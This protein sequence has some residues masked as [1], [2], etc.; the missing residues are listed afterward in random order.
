ML[1]FSFGYAAL[2]SSCEQPVRKAIPYLN[3]PEDLTPGMASHYASTFYDGNDFCP[4]VVKVRD[5]RP[6]KIEG[7]DL[8]EIYQGGTTARIQASVLNLY[9]S[10]RLK[11]PTLSGEKSDWNTIDNEI[12]SKLKEISDQDGKI[13]ILSSTIISPSTKKILEEFSAV[14]PQTEIVYYDSVSYDAIRKA[15]EGVFGERIL[16]TLRFDKADV[17][18]GF[19]ADF[20]GNWL[21]PVEYTWQYAKT[22]ELDI[23][24]KKISKHYQF[25]S[26]MT[27]TGSN[28]DYRIP[29]K[30]SEEKS[31][32][33]SRL[34]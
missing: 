22:R 11:F 12:T 18:V 34:L 31:I 3:K 9:D 16:P 28:A 14:Y 7:N 21:S 25:E 5:G 23:N 29:I 24:K 10:A 13:V 32:L 33:K 2:A 30:P 19:N 20:L 4:I 15:H 6:I 27:L 26:L 17:I 8:S 1:G